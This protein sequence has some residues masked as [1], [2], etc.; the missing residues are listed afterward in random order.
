MKTCEWLERY[1]S[2]YALLLCLDGTMRV[3][4]GFWLLML[5]GLDREICVLG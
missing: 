5:G 1:V 3:D 2:V 4:F